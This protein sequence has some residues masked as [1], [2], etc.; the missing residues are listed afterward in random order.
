MAL[1]WAGFLQHLGKRAGL[2]QAQVEEGNQCEREWQGCLTF[3]YPGAGV[4][5]MTLLGFWSLKCLEMYIG[6]PLLRHSTFNG[7]IFRDKI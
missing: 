5:G 3:S 4:G 2:V 1:I 7:K 6:Y